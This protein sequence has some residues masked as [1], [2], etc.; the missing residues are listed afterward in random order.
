MV[1]DQ[2]A[3]L[4]RIRDRGTG[5][6]SASMPFDMSAAPVSELVDAWFLSSGFTHDYRLFY[7]LCDRSLSDLAGLS[8]ALDRR[9]GEEAEAFLLGL[10]SHMETYPD[11][12]TLTLPDIASVLDAPYAAVLS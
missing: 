4:W 1:L 7:Y 12:H 11:Y 10:K 9:S 2:D 3:D 8:D 5:G 6:A